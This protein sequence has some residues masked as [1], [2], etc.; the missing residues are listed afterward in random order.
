M[1]SVT[2]KD[3]T[4]VNNQQFYRVFVVGESITVSN[5]WEEVP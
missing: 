4:N 3:N 1:S 2:S 5:F